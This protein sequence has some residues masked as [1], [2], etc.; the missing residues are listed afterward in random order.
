MANDEFWTSDSRDQN[1]FRERR[2]SPIRISFLFAC[3]VIA[4]SMMATPIIS[5]RTLV[6]KSQYGIDGYDT[7]ITGSVAPISVEPTVSNAYPGTKRQFTIRRTITE[8]GSV[9]CVVIDRY[10]QFSDC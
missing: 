7:I 1:P 2:V 5:E 8:N 9:S 6:A 3:G 4:L 10:N